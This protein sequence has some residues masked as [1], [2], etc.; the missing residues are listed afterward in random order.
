[1]P[2]L[3]PLFD[4]LIA[5][6]RPQT[7]IYWLR[8]PLGAG[9]RLL[10]EMATGQMPFSHAALKALPSDRA[11]NYLR[12]LLAAIG[13]LPHYAP[14]IARMIPWLDGK[15]ADLPTDEA[16][17]VNRLPRWRV[18]RRV[19]AR[20]ER[21]EATKGVIDRGREEINEAIRFLAWL[22]GHSATI[23]TVDQHLLDRYFGQHPSRVDIHGIFL[24]WLPAHPGYGNLQIPPTG[25]RNRWSPSPTKIAGPAS[26]SSCTTRRS[27]STC[28]SP[29]CSPCCSRS[30]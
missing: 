22:R 15:L 14:A 23:D 5:S 12:D 29:A 24:N 16:R 7:T 26:N 25:K 1:M 20:A 8:R 17:I 4:T 28:A 2:A 18:L 19:R 30:L 9:P 21:G 10:R 13:I 3:Q 27:G 6:D 11:H